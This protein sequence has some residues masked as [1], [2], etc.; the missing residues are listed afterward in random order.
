M[1]L[2]LSLQINFYWKLLIQKLSICKVDESLELFKRELLLKVDVFDEKYKS[3]V[4]TVKNN[5]SI[6]I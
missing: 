2:L 5:L 1:F 4:I 3:G 6:C